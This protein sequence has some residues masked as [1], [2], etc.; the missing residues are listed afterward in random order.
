[1]TDKIGIP[2]LA[3]RVVWIYLKIG[4]VVVMIGS[5]AAKFV[6]GGF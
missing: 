5:G 6:Y 1:M 4:A 3:I 2:A